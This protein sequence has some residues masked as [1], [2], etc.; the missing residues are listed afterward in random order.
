MSISYLELCSAGDKDCSIGSVS[1]AVMGMSMGGLE[2][3]LGEGREQKIGVQKFYYY[4]I[5]V[6]GRAY[7]LQVRYEVNMQKK[8][9]GGRVG[10]VVSEVNYY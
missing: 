2:G 4:P 1:A 10:N 6:K 8:A 9:A 3:V 7:T 5:S